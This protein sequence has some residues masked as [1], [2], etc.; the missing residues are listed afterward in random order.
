MKSLYESILDDEDVLINDVKKDADNPLV[1][2]YSIYK[3]T[4]DLS[5]RLKVVDSIAIPLIEQLKLSKYRM[6]ICKDDIKIVDMSN[7][8]GH[9]YNQYN[10]VSPEGLMF[11]IRFDRDDYVVKRNAKCII[12][13]VGAQRLKRHVKA[14]EEFAKKY[15]LEKSPSGTRYIL[16]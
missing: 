12:I 2:L 11:V 7:V 8:K 14:L 13:E 3:E 15:N 4:S 6:F 9:W 16:W 10:V 5:S 1:K